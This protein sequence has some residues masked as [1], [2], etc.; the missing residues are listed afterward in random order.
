MRIDKLIIAG[1]VSMSLLASCADNGKSPSGPT[2]PMRLVLNLTGSPTLKSAITTAPSVASEN[3]INYLTVGLFDAS[4][5]LVSL[6]N[7]TG[8]ALSGNVATVTGNSLVTKVAVAVNVPY[9]L[10][11]SVKKLSDFEN[12]Q[13]NLD[14]TA[15]S[16]ASAA[17]TTQQYATALPMAGEGTVTITPNGTS[18]STGTATVPLTRLVSK[19]TLTGITSTFSSTGAYPTA[20]FTPTEVFMYNTP[21]AANCNLTTT[22][23][24]FASTPTFLQGE[25]SNLANQKV[26]LGTGTL[27]AQALPWTGNYIFYVF[28]NNN[29]TSQMELII[30][31]TFKTSGS[32]PGT[33]VYYPII[34]NH[35][36][37]GTTGGSGAFVPDGTDGVVQNNRAFSLT[38]NITSMGVSSPSSTINTATVNVTVSLTAWPTVINQNAT[39]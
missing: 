30:K 8:A 27:T 22:T 9:S 16:D 21:S 37:T 29:G 2:T 7:L 23:S 6:T 34:I 14:Y 4:N 39:F 25:S 1:I 13:A 35:A 26:Y 18:A 20:S 32:D 31:G 3:T 36:M 24:V 28:P 10:F 19:I 11:A 33:T 38:A 17:G 15:T 12:V 5:N